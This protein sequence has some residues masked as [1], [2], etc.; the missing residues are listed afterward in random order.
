[1]NSFLRVALFLGDSVLANIFTIDDKLKKKFQDD[2]S[3]D[4]IYEEFVG[5]ADLQYIARRCF[6]KFMALISKNHEFF[7]VDVFLCAGAVDLSNALT[8][9]LF[10]EGAFL[11]QRFQYC[12]TIMDD[13]FVRKLYLFPLTP[14]NVCKSQLRKRF[15]HY[16]DFSWIKKANTHIKSLNQA[17]TDKHH[18]KL[19]NVSVSSVAISKKLTKDGLHFIDDG[20]KQIFSGLWQVEA[21]PFDVAE[22]DYPLLSSKNSKSSPIIQSLEYVSGKYVEII[23]A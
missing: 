2:F 17:L 15:P 18:A 22:T 21:K 3:Y 8:K 4:Y 1:M 23:K 13:P 5:G 9:S 16:G 10:Q 7:T 20:K 11:K 12:K 6:P 19:I 14:R